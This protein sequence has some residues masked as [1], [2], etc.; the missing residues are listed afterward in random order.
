MKANEGL[1][2]AFVDV[3]RRNLEKCSRNE[4]IRMIDS[5]NIPYSTYYTNKE[6]IERIITE[7][8]KGSMPNRVVDTNP[9]NE[10]KKK[11]KVYGK[12]IPKFS[13]FLFFFFIFLVFASLF[14][15]TF[16][17]RKNGFCDNGTISKHCTVC[18]KHAE[19]VNG[20][21]ECKDG[22]VLLDKHCIVDDVD[23][24]NVSVVLNYALRTIHN[25][26]GDFLCGAAKN[27]YYTVDQL[28]SCIYGES[29]VDSSEFPRIFTKVLDV[30]D[31]DTEVA[32]QTL[33]NEKIFVSLSP[34]RPPSCIVKRFITASFLVYLLIVF[35]LVVVRQVYR[36]YKS[37]NRKKKIA[38][39]Q[40]GI[41]YR[42]M[43]SLA[44]EIDSMSL[45]NKFRG[46]SDIDISIWNLIEE[47]LKMSPRVI[48]KQRRGNLFFKFLYY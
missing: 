17:T 48:W 4:L 22:Y 41:V 2:D 43:Q 40:A 32:K 18:P 11:S 25:R 28:D 21:A 23:A 8:K 1:D 33:N 44:T 37:Y 15:L 24:G 30:L 29:I 31:G 20:N 14:A 38:I 45:K 12:V 47:S 42:E 16:R 39:Y 19:C 27:D 26:A 34:N 46:R 5:L 36:L 3:T 6:I 35:V 7:M 9:D 13:T 10:K